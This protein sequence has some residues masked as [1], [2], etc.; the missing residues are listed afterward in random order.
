MFPIN[1]ANG[2]TVAFSARVLPGKEA[3]E[4]LG[5]Y[6]NSPQTLIYD[7]SKILFGLD[8]A[9]REIKNKDSAIIVEGQMDAITAHENGYAN[10]IASSGTALSNEQVALLKRYSNNI[11]L[12][13]DADAA[14]E[15]ASERGMSAALKAGMNARVI[16]LP[17]GKDP[18][19]CI[20]KD[21]AGWEKAVAEAKPVMEYYFQ[22]VFANLDLNAAEDRSRATKKLLPIIAEL[23]NKMERDFWLKKLSSQIDAR[24]ETLHEEMAK[25]FRQEERVKPPERQ[26]EQKIILAREEILSEIMLALIIKFPMLIEYALNRLEP[27]QVAMSSKKLYKTVLN[28]YNNLV[29]NW[30]REGGGLNAG[31]LI[32]RISYAD[33]RSWLESEEETKNELRIF[34]K[35][36]LLGDR[37]FYNYETEKAKSELTNIIKALKKIYLINRRNE[38]KK[39]ITQA[40]EE[41][42]ENNIKSLFEELKLLNDEVMG[43]GD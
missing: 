3:A 29:D 14:G 30:T 32:P 17:S 13:F 7:K 9:K 20:K 1:D 24:E 27:D 12:S 16:I 10:V 37:D 11:A 23:G 40:E 31:G 36:A 15:M 21:K 25:Y 5:K 34:E 8:K 2:S 35:L 26:P 18:D 43:L 38:I 22:K 33:F 6:I 39:L 41:K 28:Y 42:N 19:E 4:K